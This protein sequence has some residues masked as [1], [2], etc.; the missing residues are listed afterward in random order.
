MYGSLSPF[1]SVKSPAGKSNMQWLTLRGYSVK[2]DLFKLE[3][4]AISVR[5]IQSCFLG[6]IWL[7]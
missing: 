6:L 2:Y 7:P 4:G 5:L 3:N 1:T